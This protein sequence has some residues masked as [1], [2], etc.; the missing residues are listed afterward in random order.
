MWMFCAQI[1]S[2]VNRGGAG[3][4]DGSWRSWNG[5]W[6]GML[7]GNGIQ[8]ILK[9]QTEKSLNGKRFKTSFVFQLKSIFYVTSEKIISKRR[10]PFGD[11]DDISTCM[12]K[13]NF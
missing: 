8:E 4:M 9:T 12:V 11:S 1:D 6:S 5:D 3:V 13:F 2:R 10:K 7:F